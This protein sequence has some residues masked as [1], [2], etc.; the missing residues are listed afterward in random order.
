MLEDPHHHML[1]D[2]HLHM[3]EDPHHHMLEDPH[4]DLEK[5]DPLYIRSTAFVIV[6][7][8]L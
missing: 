4:E 1:E 8:R 5:L 2:P 7:Y 6:G 3:L